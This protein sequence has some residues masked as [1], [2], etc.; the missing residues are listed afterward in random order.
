MNQGR[1]LKNS[2]YVGGRQIWTTDS[3]TISLSTFG[4]YT[5]GANTFD[6]TPLGD[7]TYC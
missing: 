1:V 7:T 2:N 4:S 6:V 5:L 3:V